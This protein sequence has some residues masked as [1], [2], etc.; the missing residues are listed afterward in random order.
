VIDE[1]NKG[2]RDGRRNSEQNGINGQGGKGELDNKRNKV[3]Q[4]NGVIA[5]SNLLRREIMNDIASWLPGVLSKIFDDYDVQMELTRR[6]EEIDSRV[7]WEAG[8]YGDRDAYLAF[9]PNFHNDLLSVT[10]TL[11]GT[12]P[13]IQGWHFFGAK[14]RKQWPVRKVL[15]NEIECLFD[16]WRYRLVMFKNGDFFDIDFF[17]FDEAIEERARAGLGVFL[18]SSE[19]GEKLFML[20]IDRVNVSTRPQDGEKSIHIESLYEQIIDLYRGELSSD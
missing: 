10:E 7:Q 2:D 18:A 12:M 4:K 3:D 1:Y 9:S 8:P 6:L 14:P 5:G 20:A 11:A 13:T 19:L 17:A 15:F 16:S